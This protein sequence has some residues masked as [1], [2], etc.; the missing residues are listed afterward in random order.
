MSPIHTRNIPA[1]TAGERMRG[2][3]SNQLQACR[4]TNMG[5]TVLSRVPIE[6]EIRVLCRLAISLCCRTNVTPT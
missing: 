2:V 6:S 5:R 1:N 4:E 3:A